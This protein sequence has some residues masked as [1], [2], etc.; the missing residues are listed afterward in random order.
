MRKTHLEL[1]LLLLHDCPHDVEGRVGEAEHQQ[2]RQLVLY[3]QDED[4]VLVGGVGKARQ[5]HFDHQVVRGGA[6]VRAH[7]GPV[8][9][10]LHGQEPLSVVALKEDIT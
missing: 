9:G 4:V 10:V 3:G 8:H 6:V 5:D 2:Q 1:S 7:D